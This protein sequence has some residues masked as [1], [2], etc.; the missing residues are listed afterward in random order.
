[1]SRLLLDRFNNTIDT[2]I[3]YL[4][5][6]TLDELRHKPIPNSWSLGQVY[7][8]ITED[9]PWHI[10]QMRE[11]LATDDNSAEDKHQD[12]K[13][14]FARNMFPDIQIEG[15]STNESV[16]QPESKEEIFDLLLDIK[17]EVNDLYY[18][19]RFNSKGKTRHPGLLYFS[20]AEWLQFTEM[21]MRHHFKQKER[22]DKATLSLRRNK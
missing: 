17:K 4:D 1:M 2:W 20:A 18:E 13:M 8:H 7:I 14:M 11:A 6:Y 21:H 5:D 12:A 10:E 15:A 3:K 9:T 16:R 19:Y 22:I